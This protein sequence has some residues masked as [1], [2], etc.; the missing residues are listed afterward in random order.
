MSKKYPNYTL[1]C[2]KS[3]ANDPRYSTLVT[4]YKE[5]KKKGYFGCGCTDTMAIETFA[6]SIYPEME[7]GLIEIKWKK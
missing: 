5:N 6:L 4:V 1:I 2:E 3:I 7:K